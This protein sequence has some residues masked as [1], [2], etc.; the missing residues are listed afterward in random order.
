MLVP[1]DTPCPECSHPRGDHQL[2]TAFGEECTVCGCTATWVDNAIVWDPSAAPTPFDWTFA[3]I[4]FFMFIEE[5]EFYT[6]TI[7]RWRPGYALQSGE[8]EDLRAV[9]GLVRDLWKRYAPP[10]PKPADLTV[11]S[12]AEENAA[13][14][15]YEQEKDHFW[16]AIIRLLVTD[17]W[18]SYFP[19]REHPAIESVRQIIVA[20]GGTPP[21]SEIEEWK[22]NG[23][24]PSP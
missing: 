18:R 11:R 1:Q 8:I 7:D 16:G 6:D 5:E 21:D 22:R 20:H 15:R 9:E 19:A 24:P 2:T 10:K 13:V 14:D 3:L 17:E 12:V 23:Q 4:T